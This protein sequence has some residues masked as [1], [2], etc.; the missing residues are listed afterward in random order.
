MDVADLPT[1]GAGMGQAKADL[2]AK[3][4]AFAGGT[5]Y[6]NNANLASAFQIAIWEIVYDFD[7]STLASLDITDGALKANVNGTIGGLVGSLLT[8]AFG[9]ASMADLIGMGNLSHQDQII[10][11][12]GIIPGPGSLALLGLGAVLAPRRRRA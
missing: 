9:S 8:G 7:G 2:V 11:I 12:T 6:T 10:D 4:Y 5:Q 1:P 3:L